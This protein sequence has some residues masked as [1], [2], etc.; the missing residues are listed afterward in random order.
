MAWSKPEVFLGR[1]GK[2]IEQALDHAESEGFGVRS[3][4]TP[5]P[6]EQVFAFEQGH[7]PDTVVDGQDAYLRGEYAFQYHR[8]RS[9]LH[10]SQRVAAIPGVRNETKGI[11]AANLPL[12]MGL[13][14][15]YMVPWDQPKGSKPPN[16]R[17]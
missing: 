12:R 10:D 13:R 3:I 1:L 2:E 16:P 11:A 8:Y 15:T 6:I 9:A 5:V 14:E 7:G 4:E 17:A